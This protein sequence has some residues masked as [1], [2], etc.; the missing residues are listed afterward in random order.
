MNDCPGYLVITPGILGS[1][2]QSTGLLN[3]EILHSMGQECLYLFFLSC[4]LKYI[5]KRSSLSSTDSCWNLVESGQFPEFW[6]NQFWQRGLPNWSNDSGRISNRIQITLEWFRDSPGRNANGIRRNGI[7]TP[8]SSVGICQCSI[9][10]SSTNNAHSFSTTIIVHDAHLA[11]MTNARGH[12]HPSPTTMTARTT[13]QCHISKRTSSYINRDEG[14]HVA[15]GNVATKWW[16]T[17]MSSFIVFGDVIM[18]STPL[19]SSQVNSL[20]TTIPPTSAT[21]PWPITTTTWQPHHHMT[22]MSPQ[23]T[24]TPTTPWPH[25]TTQHHNHHTTNYNK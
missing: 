13:W 5:L 11:T 6:R 24:A 3:W 1:L 17:M 16:M 2:S 23:H 10:V 12:A 8:K 7:M 22:T 9:W 21:S 15:V 25:T 19:P 20:T 14:C 18:V 4:K